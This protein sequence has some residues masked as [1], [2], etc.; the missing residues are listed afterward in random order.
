MKIKLKCGEGSPLLRPDCRASCIHAP[1]DSTGTTA[2]PRSCRNRKGSASQHQPGTMLEMATPR[3]GAKTNSKLSA[4]KLFTWTQIQ[5]NGFGFLKRCNSVAGGLRQA[6]FS[7]RSESQRETFELKSCW[8]FRSGGNARRHSPLSL[9]RA[10][11]TGLHVQ[12]GFRRQ[13]RFPV[14]SPASAHATK[15]LF[16]LPVNPSFFPLSDPVR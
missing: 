4:G 16:L 9:K 5:V 10:R 11:R 8:G 1:Y 7:G 15:Y 2:L 12:S 3:N 13:R 14:G 6:S